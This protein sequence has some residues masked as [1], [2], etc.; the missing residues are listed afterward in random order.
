MLE[1]IIEILG[2]RLWLAL[3]ALAAPLTGATALAVA[4]PDLYRATATVLVQHEQAPGPAGGST[5][6]AGVETRLRTIRE[7]IL[8]RQRLDAMIE[9]FGLYP[10]I[11]HRA[12]REA[13]VDRMRREIQIQLNG[14]EQGGVQDGTIAFS[15]SFRGGD[16]SLAAAVANGLAESYV[17]ENLRIRGRQAEATAGA[18]E[19]QLSEIRARLEGQEARI[20]DYQARHNGELPQQVGINMARIQQ[21]GMQL[22]M[23]RDS[24]LRA[25]DRRDSLGG[26]IT[27]AGFAEP[28]TSAE[29]AVTS[30]ARLKRQ[31]AELRTT[32]SDNYPDIVRIKGQIAVMEKRLRG[33]TADPEASGPDAATSRSTVVRRLK[34]SMGQLETELDRLKGEE[35]RLN[36][37][38]ETYQS[39]VDAAPQREQEF[40]EL[41]RD[42]STTKELYASL[43]KRYQEAK[44]ADRME[45]GG[46]GEQLRILDSA[47]RPAFPIA[48]NRQRLVLFG[49]MLSLAFAAGIVVLR[50]QIDTSFHTIDDLRSFT[51]IPVLVSIPPLK[52]PADRRKRLR[53]IGLRWIAAVC[54]LALIAAACWS[55]GSGNLEFVRLLARGSA[56]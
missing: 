56:T 9:R 10:E 34:G 14:T 41:S 36:R 52:A 32:Y 25:R 13:I 15:L 48:P 3:I 18:L 2:R 24:Q 55:F 16:P 35:E 5:Q 30:L 12:P 45:R 42:Y 54:G 39:R 43:L 4:L 50:E 53:R 20:G 19:T 31:L 11:R 17:E 27:D 29:S 6:D 37:D 49:L 1:P 22:Q 23:N 28:S 7:E 33:A 21:L 40:A 51:C 44:L 47:V 8:S 38:I 46:K 26:A